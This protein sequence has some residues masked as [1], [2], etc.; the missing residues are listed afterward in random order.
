MGIQYG[1]EILNG[2]YVLLGAQSRM[3]SQHK[4][5]MTPTRAARAAGELGD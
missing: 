4:S 3:Q 2:F 5:E 1:E